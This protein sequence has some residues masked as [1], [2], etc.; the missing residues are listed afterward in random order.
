V[1]VTRARGG[2]RASTRIVP[3]AFRG[4]GQHGVG[5]IQQRRLILVA[6]DI[7]MPGRDQC[8]IRRLDDFGR[9]VR[10]HM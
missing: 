3:R 8:P 5:V 4:I 2:A 10:L 6:T 9:S 7:R 1:G